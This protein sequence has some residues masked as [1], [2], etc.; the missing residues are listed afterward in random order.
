MHKGVTYLFFAIF[1]IAILTHAGGFAK[2]IT[3]VGGQATQETSL[4]TG[5]ASASKAP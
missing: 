3:S 5:A 2:A 4:L 1:L